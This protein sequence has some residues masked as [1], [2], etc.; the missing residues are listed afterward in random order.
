M[1]KGPRLPCFPKPLTVSNC[2]AVGTELHTPSAALNCVCRTLPWR[3]TSS[4]FPTNKPT[5]G[6]RPG[7][8]DK[9][10]VGCQLLRL[11]GDDGEPKAWG[12]SFHSSRD[13][14][15]PEGMKISGLPSPS[16]HQDLRR[17]LSLFGNSIVHT[18]EQLLSNQLHPNPPLLLLLQ[19]DSAQGQFLK[20]PRLCVLLSRS[21]YATR[22]PGHCFRPVAASPVFNGSSS[23]RSCFHE[24]SMSLSPH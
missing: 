5:V 4:T 3:R 12:T 11:R 18:R 9:K 20:F 6:C 22:K 17:G 24:R 2:R 23:S 16:L 19:L 10:G 21:D 7:W 15:R 13:S 1:R 14:A 8:R